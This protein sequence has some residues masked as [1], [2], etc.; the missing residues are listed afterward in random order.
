M[1]GMCA[2]VFLKHSIILGAYAI[3]EICVAGF[4]A[5]DFRIGARHEEECYL[6]EIRQ[7]MFVAID[8]PVVRIPLEREML[9]RGILFETK[10]T[11][12]RDLSRWSTQSP[13]LLK[14]AFF[15]WLL[16]KMFRQN[17]DAIEESLGS[18]IWLAQFENQRV[19]IDA[20]YADR[21]TGD[22]Q[23]VALGRVYIFIQVNVETENNIIHREGVAI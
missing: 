10:W 8:L 23:C 4:E 14:L 12:A 2:L 18:G 15:I 16:E 17:R 6:V 9:S 20:M 22:D 3:D 5:D 19:G 13:G 11:E 7:S 1:K 21:L